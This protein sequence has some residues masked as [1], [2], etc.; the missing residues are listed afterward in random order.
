MVPLIKKMLESVVCLSKAGDVIT[1]TEKK[2]GLDGKHE[3]GI[4]WSL[5]K[6]HPYIIDKDTK[7]INSMPGLK[8]IEVEILKCYHSAPSIG[9]G[10][11]S[12]KRK[13]KKEY[14]TLKPAEI[15]E[16]KKTNEITEIIKMPEFVFYGNTNIDALIKHHEWKKYPVLIIETAMYNEINK[17]TKLFEHIHWDQMETIIK[18]NPDN[19]FFLIH[20]SMSVD[21]DFLNK[22]ENQKRKSLK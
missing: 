22:F 18:D 10:F 12:F 1:E 14:S 2:L 8:N 15:K 17:K 21:E 4:V 20:S 16:I 19:F 6:T 13:L 11:S 3:N 7:I 9:F 5:Q